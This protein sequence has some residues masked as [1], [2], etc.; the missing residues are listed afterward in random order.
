M[1]GLLSGLGG[2]QEF[3]TACQ[4]HMPML[5]KQSMAMGLEF[6][7]MMQGGTTLLL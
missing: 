6:G 7:G 4:K 1:T 3:L 2:S 5:A